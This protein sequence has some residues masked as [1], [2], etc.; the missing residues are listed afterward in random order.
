MRLPWYWDKVLTELSGRL[1]QFVV[2][3]GR[4]Q[5]DPMKGKQH[6]KA[7]KTNELLILKDI[8]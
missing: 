3:L 6:T 4:T 2:G 8:S 7:A 1:E 5:L